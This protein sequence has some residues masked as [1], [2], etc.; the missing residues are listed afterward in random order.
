[1]ARKV[2]QTKIA[3]ARNNHITI[4]ISPKLRLVMGI[5]NRMVWLQAKTY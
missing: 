3:W 1:M 2:P 4:R 5:L